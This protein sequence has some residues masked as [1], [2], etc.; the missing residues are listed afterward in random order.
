MVAHWLVL[1]E[2]DPDILTQRY[3][4]Q[5]E[6]TYLSVVPADEFATEP[7]S[8]FRFASQLARTEPIFA[9]WLRRPAIAIRVRARPRRDDGRLTYSLGGAPPILEVVPRGTSR[10]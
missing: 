1:H 3:M 2:D 10:L 6:R 7:E 9:G 4:R 8:V 5:L